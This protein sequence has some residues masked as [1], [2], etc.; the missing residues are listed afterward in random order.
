MAAADGGL[1]ALAE[2][3]GLMSELF[4]RDLDGVPARAAELVLSKG[5]TGEDSRDAAGEFDAEDTLFVCIRL[6]E[7][8][9]DDSRGRL[10]LVVVVEEGG[11]GVVVDVIDGVD[12]EGF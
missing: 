2:R 12:V 3:E 8:L 4:F 1:C 10:E 7:G 11:G 5:L 6:I 9:A